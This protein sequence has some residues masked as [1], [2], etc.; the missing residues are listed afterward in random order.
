MKIL[1]MG[2]GNTLLRDEGVGVYAVRELEAMSWPEG[3]EFVDGGIFSQDLFHIYQDYEMLVVLDCVKAGGEPGTL[4][5]LE[6]ADLARA[7]RKAVGVHDF[8]MLD[9]LLFAEVLGGRRPRLLVLGVEP[10]AIE[11]G[12]GLTPPVAEALPALARAAEAELR[13]ILDAGGQSG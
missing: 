1:V 7:S 9:S 13:A 12:E 6:E 3:V 8:G 5:R 4:H 2:I 10:G 11:Y